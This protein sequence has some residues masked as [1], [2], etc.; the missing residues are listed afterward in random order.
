MVKARQHRAGRQGEA[1]QE[2]IGIDRTAP[3]R[4]SVASRSA[5]SPQAM[6]GLRRAPCPARRFPLP[7]LRRSDLMRSPLPRTSP[8]GIA[9][10]CALQHARRRRPIDALFLARQLLRIGHAVLGCGSGCSVSIASSA[11]SAAAR[12]APQA[13]G[14]V[15]NA[16]ACGAIG[17]RAL[18][19]IG[20]VSRPSSICMMVTPVSPSP[21]RIARWIGAAP[22]QRGSSEA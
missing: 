1:A 16:V 22:R 17:T 21:A 6:V 2:R 4:C 20:P 7:A 11:R 13:R 14:A 19:S 10:T 18:S 9:R 5:P 3:G 12:R 8:G 15:R